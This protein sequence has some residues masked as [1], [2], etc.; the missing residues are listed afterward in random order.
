MPQ[1]AR[2]VC[3]IPKI[4][5]SVSLHAQVAAPD[6]IQRVAVKVDPDPDG[7]RPVLVQLTASD[8]KA[9]ELRCVSLGAAVEDADA[10]AIPLVSPCCI[11]L[12]AA[13]PACVPIK[14]LNPHLL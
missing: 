7:A 14:L 13:C 9:K 1:V 12:H 3:N 10:D 8:D 4:A 6:R 2:D 11:N 5:S